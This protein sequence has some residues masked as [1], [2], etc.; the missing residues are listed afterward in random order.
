VSPPDDAGTAVERMLVV[1]ALPILGDLDPEELATVAERARFRDFA[2]GETLFSG[3]DAPVTT[4]HL[5]IEGSVVERRGGQPFRTHGPQHVVGGLEALAETTTDVV[6]IAETATRTL[7]IDRE[8]LRDILADNFGVLGA[9]LQGVAAAVLRLRQ[10]ARPSGGFALQAP[11]CVPVSPPGDLAERIAFLHER[12][13]LHGMPV[14]ALG[15]VAGE[16]ERLALGDGER[17]WSEGEPAGY[18]AVVTSG[19]VRCASRDGH[20]RFEVGP[21][22]IVGLEEALAL[23]ERWHEAVAHGA[24]TLLGMR[25]D[26]LVDVLEDETDAALAFLGALAATASSLRDRMAGAG[27]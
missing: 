10:A 1:K 27:E 25:S 8:A 2:P 9:T 4:I 26:T 24:V 23:G 18:G 20:H 3:V 7:A 6:A 11:E 19:I 5:V 12:T 16:A 22:A 13:W 15:Y 17:L 14:R 21:G